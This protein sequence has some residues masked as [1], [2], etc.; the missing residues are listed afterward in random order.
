[1][2]IKGQDTWD[3]FFQQVPLEQQ[4]ESDSSTEKIYEERQTKEKERQIVTTEIEKRKRK[5]NVKKK[6]QNLGIYHLV[7]YY[8]SC[9]ILIF[10]LLRVTNEL[11]QGLEDTERDEEE[12]M[13]IFL[14]DTQRE[15]KGK[16]E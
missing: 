2:I 13:E 8:F 5:R 6:K 11:R 10:E 12:V 7:I 4:K 1:M 15:T 9:L 3:L 16:K 14:R